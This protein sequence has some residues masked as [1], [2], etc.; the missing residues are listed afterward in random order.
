MDE[1]EPF[2]TSEINARDVRRDAAVT[3]AR[4]GRCD[5]CGRWNDH[6]SRARCSVRVAYIEYA[7]RRQV[8]ARPETCSHRQTISFGQST[9]SRLPPTWSQVEPC[10]RVPAP[11]ERRELSTSHQ[12]TAS[13]TWTR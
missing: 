3:L 5:A 1:G 2:D 7:A 12:P 6:S 11:I 9:P 10:S 13:A 8:S 4:F